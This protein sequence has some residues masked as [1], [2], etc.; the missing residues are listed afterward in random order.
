MELWHPNQFNLWN[1]QGN[2]KILVNLTVP[3]F[4]FG[5]SFPVKLTLRKHPAKG[6]AKFQGLDGTNAR[7][8]R[9]NASALSPTCN[10]DCPALYR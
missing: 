9:T 3:I 10:R 4:L 5:L 8:A 6:A 7:H 1:K 2:K